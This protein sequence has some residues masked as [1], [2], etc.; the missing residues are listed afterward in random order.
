[1]ECSNCNSD[2][3]FMFEA[4]KGLHLKRYYKCSKCHNRTTQNIKKITKPKWMK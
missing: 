3:I 4:I 1:M 2:M